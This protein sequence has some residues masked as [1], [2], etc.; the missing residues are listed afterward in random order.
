MTR[1]AALGGLLVLATA[2]G[3]VAQSSSEVRLDAGYASVRQFTYD[4]ADPVAYV[5]AALV[6]LLA[7]R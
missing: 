7:G 1:R 6:R 3:A 4:P 5:D 2:H